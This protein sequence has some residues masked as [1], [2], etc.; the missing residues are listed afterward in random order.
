MDTTII[1][2]T[3]ARW[4]AWCRFRAAVVKNVVAACCSG[5]GPVAV[6]MTQSTPVNAAA[7]RGELIGH[8]RTAG[9]GYAPACRVGE[10]AAI[11]DFR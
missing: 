9:L 4:P 3:P 6:S 8:A 2:R 11:S 10:V 5:E 1:R 7:K